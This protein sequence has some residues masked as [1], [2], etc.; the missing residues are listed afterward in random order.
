MISIKTILVLLVIA[1]A[2]AHIYQ[3]ARNSSFLGFIHF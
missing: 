1:C 2:S 3:S